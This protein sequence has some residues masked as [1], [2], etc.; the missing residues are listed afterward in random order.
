MLWYGTPPPNNEHDVGTRRRV[1]NNK[2]KNQSYWVEIT[3]HVIVEVKDQELQHFRYQLK[4]MG[5][6]APIIRNISI[7]YFN[8]LHLNG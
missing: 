2:K 3:T 7:H 8:L 4:L 5:I 1:Q 6:N